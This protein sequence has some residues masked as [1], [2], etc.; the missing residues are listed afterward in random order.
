MKILNSKQTL[1]IFLGIFMLLSIAPVYAQQNSILN[2]NFLNKIS[3]HD[4][5]QIKNMF[6]NRYK[7]NCSG[8]CE[9]SE[10]N[11]QLQLEVRNQKRFV[12]LNVDSVDTYDLNEDGEI[13]RA[14]HNIWYR[15]LNR[16][17]LS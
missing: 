4:A 13:I 14:R 5:N 8:E 7:L 10:N 2:S 3:S 17:K 11:E 9:Y 16:E 6:Q 12:F 15:L 1:S